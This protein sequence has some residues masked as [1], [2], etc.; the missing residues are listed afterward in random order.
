MSTPGVC[1]A[2]KRSVLQVPIGIWGSELVRA[3]FDA[4]A[5]VDDFRT[6]FDVGNLGWSE[7]FP[8]NS[9]ALIWAALPPKVV[10]IGRKR[11]SGR[12]W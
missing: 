5:A 8:L 6:G 3:E 11:R 2:P 9:R 7:A 4:A 1:C 10:A 12:R